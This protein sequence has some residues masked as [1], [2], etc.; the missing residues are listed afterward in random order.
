MR[1]TYVNTPEDYLAASRYQM[2]HSPFGSRWFRWIRLTLAG[3][4]ILFVCLPAW[5]SWQNGWNW[6]ASVAVVLAAIYAFVTIFHERL[7]LAFTEWWARRW[8]TKS[9]S[10]YAEYFRER[11]LELEAGQIID[12]SPKGYFVVK[13]KY[14]EPLM[15]TTDHTIVIGPTR[16]YIIPRREGHEAEYDGFTEALREQWEQARG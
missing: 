10:K 15:S 13:L 1:I 7:L 6:I 9:N 12:H 14:V 2:Q 16:Y 4:M 8:F 5:M 3:M 11:D